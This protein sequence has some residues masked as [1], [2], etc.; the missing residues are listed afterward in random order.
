M[1][2]EVEAV[3]DSDRKRGGGDSSNIDSGGSWQQQQQGQATITTN[4]N[5]RQRS[6]ALVTMVVATNITPA[7]KAAVQQPRHRPVVDVDDDAV[8]VPSFL[9]SHHHHP[10]RR[11]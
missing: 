7:V 1:E 8:D 9:L 3:I 2:A 11:R 10:T 6:V 4:T 5:M